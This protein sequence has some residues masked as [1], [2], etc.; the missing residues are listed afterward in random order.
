ML[1]VW[2]INNL[3]GDPSE[4]QIITSMYMYGSVSLFTTKAVVLTNAEMW[5]VQNATILEG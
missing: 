4:W 1:G 3:L 5:K 2:D